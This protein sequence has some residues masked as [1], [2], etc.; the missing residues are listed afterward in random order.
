M[1]WMLG[2]ARWGRLSEVRF[3][4][5]HCFLLGLMYL[6]PSLGRLRVLHLR[7]RLGSRP[8]PRASQP[9][10]ARHQRVRG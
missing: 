8:E 3:L 10:H 2:A 1:T 9:E 4:F 5:V 7:L 6:L